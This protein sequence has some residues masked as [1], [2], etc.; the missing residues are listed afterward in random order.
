MAPKRLGWHR[1]VRL[2]AERR[3]A[4]AF[5]AGIGFED[6]G[7]LELARRR[8]F[9]AIRRQDALMA[10]VWAFF[11]QPEREVILLSS[12]GCGVTGDQCEGKREVAA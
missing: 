8:Y 1:L 4:Q 11:P 10:R 7:A 9:A 6:R 2:M 12:G 5:Y 3:S